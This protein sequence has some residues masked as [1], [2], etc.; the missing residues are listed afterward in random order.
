MTFLRP[1]PLRVTRTL[2]ILVVV[3]WVAQMAVLLR[4][5]VEA[6]SMTLGAD[7]ARYG[8]AAQWKGVYSRGEK[9]GPRIRGAWVRVQTNAHIRQPHSAMR[10]AVPGRSWHT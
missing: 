3:A 9:T 4:R 5:T 2:S 6:S 1:L 7:L 10:A 8:T